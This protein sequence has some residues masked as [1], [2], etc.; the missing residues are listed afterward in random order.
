ML[1]LVRLHY[2]GPV[3]EL[4]HELLLQVVVIVLVDDHVL[5]L[6]L[7]VMVVVIKLIRDIVVK[8]LHFKLGLFPTII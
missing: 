5:L 3:L 4:L 7:L 1:L 8:V 2:L 6:L